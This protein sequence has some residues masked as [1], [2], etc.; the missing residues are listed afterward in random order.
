MAARTCQPGDHAAPFSGMCFCVPTPGACSSMSALSPLRPALLMSIMQTVMPAKNR[1]FRKLLHFCWEIYPKYN[2]N[3][4]SAMISVYLRRNAPLPP[5]NIPGSQT[6][7]TSHPTLPANL[8][9][10]Y[11]SI[12]R[13][14]MFA[15]QNLHRQ[16]PS[17]VPEHMGIELSLSSAH[18]VVHPVPLFANRPKQL[19]H[20]YSSDKSKQP[21]ILVNPMFLG[22]GVISPSY[23]VQQTLVYSEEIWASLVVPKRR[24]LKQHV[25]ETQSVS[26]EIE[27]KDS[28]LELVANMPVIY[29]PELTVRFTTACRSDHHARYPAP[30]NPHIWI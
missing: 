19:S 21:S 30:S 23:G 9:H 14:A 2:E 25:A 4:L 29:S 5:A 17:L 1:Q 10:Q 22:L 13:A 11:S 28:Y 27:K 24:K 6:P 16:H 15:L 20:S 26:L 18:S 3:V 8:K 12:R 7:R